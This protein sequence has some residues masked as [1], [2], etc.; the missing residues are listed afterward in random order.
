MPHII[1]CMRH[2]ELL[3]LITENILQTHV[4]RKSCLSSPCAPL[5]P[6]GLFL[7]AAEITLTELIWV[8]EL[9]LFGAIV[10]AFQRSAMYAW[11]ARDSIAEAIGAALAADYLPDPVFP[12]MACARHSTKGRPHLSLLQ[13]TRFWPCLA[14]RKTECVLDVW[15][16]VH[17]R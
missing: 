8:L 13:I 7:I 2:R 1:V 10:N 3:I 11:E 14:L 6:L 9:V 4:D 15:I 17:Y 12:D 16:Y 5:G